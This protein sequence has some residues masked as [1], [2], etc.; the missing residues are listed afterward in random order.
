MGPF[1]EAMPNSLIRLSTGGVIWIMTDTY[2]PCLI[3]FLI[4]TVSSA[5]KGLKGPDI[6]RQS[7]PDEKL[8]GNS[9]PACLYLK[10]GFTEEPRQS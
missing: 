2:P 8:S 4:V 9:L 1:V 7:T 10:T 5:V 6:T 3:K